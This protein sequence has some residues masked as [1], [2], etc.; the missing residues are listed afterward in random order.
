MATFNHPAQPL[1]YM[2]DGNPKVPVGYPTPEGSKRF[3]PLDGELSDQHGI[4]QRHLDGTLTNLTCRDGDGKTFI[5]A[6]SFGLGVYTPRR[7]GDSCVCTF[8]A[9]DIDG[10]DH[11]KGRSEELVQANTAALMLVLATN[12]L[13]PFTVRSGGGRGTHVIVLF[14]REVDARFAVY[15]LQLVLEQVPDA[16]GIETFPRTGM[17]RDG[18]LGA[19]LALPWSGNPPKPGGTL[20][21]DAAGNPLP[22]ELIEPASEAVIQDLY[23]QWNRIRDAQE[24]TRDH[25][26]AVAKLRSSALLTVNED[27]SDISLEA[28]ARA[29][30]TIRDDFKAEPNILRVSCPN[31]AHG[32]D[33]FHICPTKGWFICHKCETKSGGPQA[34]YALMKL[35]YP[36]ESPHD[37]RQRLRALRQQQV[38]R[39]TQPKGLEV[40]P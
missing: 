12:G 9:F 8:M 35:I 25:M 32:G 37:L 16:S 29:H 11:A 6:S 33:S 26:A 39:M 17:L 31:P 19:L 5:V 14:P 2:L 24:K 38:T 4:I 7:H 36:N 30:M 23:D 18:A 27:W 28:V 40:Q 1:L 10:P 20:P 34:P 13:N 21:I 3:A 22:V 15:L